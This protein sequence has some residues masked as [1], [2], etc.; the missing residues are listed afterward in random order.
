M[1]NPFTQD[2]G[3]ELQVNNICCVS[4]LLNAKGVTY[5]TDYILQSYIHTHSSR[6][7]GVS[8]AFKNMKSCCWHTKMLQ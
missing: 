1:W 4:L 2:C 5:Y 3:S 6:T 7:N 8:L